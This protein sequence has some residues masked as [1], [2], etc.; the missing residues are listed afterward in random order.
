MPSLP[1]LRSRL[2]RGEQRSP[3]SDQPVAPRRLHEVL[4][5]GRHAPRGGRVYRRAPQPRGLAAGVACRKSS[6]SP[7]MLCSPVP[8]LHCLPF[9]LL[10]SSPSPL[11]LIVGSQTMKQAIW[12]DGRVLLQGRA[13]HCD[14][15]NGLSLSCSQGLGQIQRQDGTGRRGATRGP[16]LCAGHSRLCEVCQIRALGRRHLPDPQRRREG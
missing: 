15:L 2:P 10:D 12:R 7:A 16:F 14:I 13:H 4:H 6:S 5:D 8:C 9:S 11:T 3:L 1:T